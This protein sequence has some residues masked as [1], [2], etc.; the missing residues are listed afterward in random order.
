MMSTQNWIVVVKRN[1][2]KALKLTIL[3]NK[4]HSQLFET[5]HSL[6]GLIGLD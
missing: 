2:Q 4:I 6:H 3:E 5:Q 1:N